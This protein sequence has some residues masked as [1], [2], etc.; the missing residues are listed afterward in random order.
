MP[1][2]FIASSSITGGSCSI[3]GDDFHH[4]ARVRRAAKGDNLILVDENG[5]RFSAQITEICADK[6]I[7]SVESSATGCAKNAAP[8]D[9]MPQPPFELCLYAA[10]LKGKKFDLVIRKAVEIGVSKIVPVITERCVP[11]YTEK[12]GAKNS[13]W[14]RIALEAAKQSM[15]EHLPSV[16]EICSFG[17]IISAGAW[18]E[19]IIAHIRGADFKAYARSA[20]PK[21]AGILIGP[22]G[23]FSSLELEKAERAGWRQLTFGFPQMRAE[24]AAVIIPAVIIHEWGN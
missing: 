10:L 20:K 24:T 19:R 16:E 7:C 1:N 12:S 17:E 23:G 18:D 4:L 21:S 15:R 2:Y 13:R 5:R 14:R 3:T 22:E 11:D 6:I 8:P 9:R